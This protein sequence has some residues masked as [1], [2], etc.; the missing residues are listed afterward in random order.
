MSKSTSQAS[1]L[2]GTAVSLAKKVT[3]SGLEVLHHFSPTVTPLDH[4]YDQT[5]VIEG[6]AQQSY[7]FDK[8]HYDLPQHMIREHLPRLSS[9]LLGRHY[10]RMSKVGQMI[11]PELNQKAAD[12]FFDYLN[13]WVS[14]QSSVAQLLDEVGAK[15]LNELRTDPERSHRISQALGNQNKI[16]AVCLGALTGATGVV[17]AAV[18]VPSS[19]VLALK[20][21]YQTG[22]AYGFDLNA[23]DYIAVEYIFKHIDMGSVAEKQALLAALRAFSELLSSHD[24]SHLQSLVGSSNDLAPL[25]AWLGSAKVPT[26]LHEH[27]STTQWSALAVLAKFTPIVGMGVGALYSC[28][29]VTDATVKAEQIFSQARYFLNLHPDTELDPLSAYFAQQEQIQSENMRQ[30]NAIETEQLSGKM[31]VDSSSTITAITPLAEQNSEAANAVEA[32]K[33][34]KSDQVT[35]ISSGIEVEGESEFKGQ[36][37]SASTPVQAV[38]SE[39]AQHDVTEKKLQK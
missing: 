11:S 6:Q 39:T 13:E 22:R 17:G 28:H 37:T 23:E 7:S 33:Q 1:G 3:Q 29:L 26:W 9:Q 38:E 19:L 18:D 20:S 36:E 14:R 8:K 35:V 21:I 16:I 4:M 15:N 24:L 25:K 12:Y 2:L 34:S 27:D 31:T 5:S 32:A 10:T 30:N